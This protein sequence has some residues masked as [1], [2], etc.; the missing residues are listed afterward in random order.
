MSR[1][2]RRAWG[3]GFGIFLLALWEGLALL[4][5]KKYILPGPWDVLCALWEF[6]VEIFTV[7]LPAT[8][9]VILIGGVLSVLIGA[10]FAVF[11][12]V[13]PRV[14]RALY[15]ILTVS[16]TIPTM[17]LAPIFVLW[18]GYSVRMRILV[19]ILINFFT[20]TVN[21]YDGLQSTRADRTELLAT[22]GA[23]RTQQFWKL[24]LPSAMPYFFSA[25]KVTVPWAV[26]GAAVSEWL[27]APSG[28]GTFSRARMMDLDAAGLL[29][30]LLVL[31]VLALLLNGVLG[32]AEK[33]C[34]HWRRDPA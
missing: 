33:K 20:V 24:R 6:R 18:L 15:P 30:P 13:D 32:F 19:V 5:G 11:M 31:T 26:I 14:E 3:I 10:L 4:I 17:C 34:L 7:H 12:D 29:A 16:Q 23:S 9:E 27:G 25:L 1:K 28:L 8:L 22:F 21:L 2:S